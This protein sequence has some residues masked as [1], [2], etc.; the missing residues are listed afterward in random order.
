MGQYFIR[1]TFFRPEE[2][3]HETTTLPAPLVNGL[4]LL[5][6]RQS[7]KCLFFPIR[8][9]QYQAVVEA[10]EVIFVDGVGGYAHQDGIGGRLI[11]LAWRLPALSAERALYAPVP[12]D[13]IHY[14]PQQRELHRRLVAEMRSLVNQSLAQQRQLSAGTSRVLPF[15][16]RDNPDLRENPNPFANPD[17]R[18]G[19]D[20]G[21][22][23][24]PA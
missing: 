10:R 5:L 13:I 1:E 18:E 17:P 23:P 14:F 8:A 9:M 7:Q 2:H 15:R 19:P 16:R 4:R 12:C 3:L 11:R 24:R 6:G 21:D 20:P 22:Q